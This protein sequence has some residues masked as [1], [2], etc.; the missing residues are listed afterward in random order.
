[1]DTRNTFSPAL[2]VLK[3]PFY[4]AYVER[5]WTIGGKLLLI[6][7]S[8][9]GLQSLCHSVKTKGPQSV[10]NCFSET[11]CHDS[12]TLRCELRLFPNLSSLAGHRDVAA[13]WRQN[14]IPAGQ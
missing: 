4:Y 9:I 13:S 1:M 2:E 7:P 11:N 14:D 3:V 12:S 8:E 6:Q 10:N 5:K